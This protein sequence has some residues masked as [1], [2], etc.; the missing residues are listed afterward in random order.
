MT[1]IDI[2]KLE[3]EV[4]TCADVAPVLGFGQYAIHEQ[5]IKHPEQLGFPVIVIGKNVRIPKRAFLNFMEGD[6]QW[7]HITE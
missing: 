3:K 7:K 6:G 5:A 4:L 2:A 1:L